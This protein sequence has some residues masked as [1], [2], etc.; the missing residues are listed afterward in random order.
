MDIYHESFERKL[1][2]LA[3]GYAKRYGALFKY[4]VED[5]MQRVN[6]YKK[7]LHPYIVDA[8]D[9]MRAVREN[10]RPVL[11]EASQALMVSRIDTCRLIEELIFV[12]SSISTSVAIRGSPPHRVLYKDVCK[13]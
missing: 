5:E 3:D 2:L 8:A 6:S 7:R 11:V 9:Y 13:V 12:R 4:S 1:R 10:K